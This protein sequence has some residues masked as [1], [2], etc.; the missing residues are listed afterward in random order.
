[1]AFLYGVTQRKESVWFEG[2][3]GFILTDAK[4]LPF[5]PCDGHLGFFTP[6]IPAGCGYEKVIKNTLTDRW[7]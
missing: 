5:Y 2:P 1:M 6:D 4:R 7:A 3:Y